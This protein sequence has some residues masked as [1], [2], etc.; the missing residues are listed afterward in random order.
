MARPCRVQLIT[1]LV[2]TCMMAAVA[3]RELQQNAGGITTTEEPV[4]NVPSPPS[5]ECDAAFALCQKN[6]T[7]SGESSAV[8]R[9]VGGVLWASCRWRFAAHHLS[10]AAPQH[11]CHPCHCLQASLISSATTPTPGP[12]ANAYPPASRT[13]SQA[14]PVSP[15]P[16]AAA[17]HCPTSLWAT[18]CWQ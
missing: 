1:W 15:P 18:L 2:G 6:A 7:C 12:P 9:N 3:G 16:A 8:G 14:L 11:S 10:L 17:L 4:S 5:P 13:A